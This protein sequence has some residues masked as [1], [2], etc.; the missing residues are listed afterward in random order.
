MMVVEGFLAATSAASTSALVTFVVYLLMVFALAYFANRAQQGREFLSEY[1]LGGRS[2][3][4]WAFALT[5]GATVAS[6][7]SFMGFPA[8]IYTHGWSLA[9]WIC[10]YMA[11]PLVALALF[12]KR[13][14]QVGRIAQAITVPELLRKRFSSPAVGNT[15]TIIL[16]FFMF[17]YLLAQFK[18]GAQI[19]ATLLEGNPAFDGLARGFELATEGWLWVGAAE[20]SYVVCL[21]LFTISVVVYTAYGGFRAV[22]WT[23]VMQGLVMAVGVV[24][25]LVLAIHQ[26]G[27]LSR[28]TEQLAAMTPP[29]T[30]VVS[31]ELETPMETRFEAAKGDWIRTNDGGLV[32][33]KSFAEIPAGETK[34][35]NVDALK[36]TTAEE[37]EAMSYGAVK[38]VAATVLE[39]QSYAYGAE[40][41]G[42]YLMP[43]GPHPTKVG[44]FLPVFLALSFFA[45]WNFSGAGQPSYMVRQMAFRDSVVL[46]RAIIFVAVFFLII[47][48]PLVVIFTTARVLLPGWEIAPD[49]IMP[50]MAAALTENAGVPWLA[51]LLVAAPFAAIMSSVDSFLLLVSSGVVRDIYQQN[52][53]LNASEKQIKRLTHWVTIL[54]G[55]AGVIAVLNPPN[56][57]QTL[58]VFASAGLGACFLVPMVLA[59]YWPRMTSRGAVAGMI[60]GGA[61]ILL[62]YLIGAVKYGTFQEY[63]PFDLHPFIYSM[64]TAFLAVV[65]VSLRDSTPDQKLVERFFGK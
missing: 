3:G 57:L 14:N 46:R 25:M 27:G 63:A 47:Y 45:F 17:F 16:V 7:G 54:L 15:A 23:D 60:T 20:G 10:G 43:P 26:V 59:L 8:L 22:V 64:F 11:C 2:I 33:L 50:E 49:R 58:I 65:L 18:A 52:I 30:V 21:I 36:L 40:Q 39:S 4:L 53:N 48:L 34:S 29:E 37:I 44:G 24:I 31:L 51:G 5:Y 55:V 32:R 61:T 9:W 28:A 6:G 19:M 38:G 12:A 1:F 56:F 35:E 41:P 13:I 42:V 62:F